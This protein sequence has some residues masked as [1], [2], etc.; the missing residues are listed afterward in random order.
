MNRTG[1]ASGRTSVRR[2]GSIAVALG[3][4]A[5]GTLMAA[6]PAQAA[7]L[8][9][10]GRWDFCIETT[11]D[12]PGGRM[13]VS[14]NGDVVQICD[15]DAD[16]KRAVGNVYRGSRAAGDA[17]K[18]YTFYDGGNNSG[19]ETRRAGMG[20]KFNLIENRVYTFQI[21]I[22]DDPGRDRFCSSYEE[23]N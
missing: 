12:N 22:D 3:L 19:C 14:M 11:D 6:G 5:A 18:V 7:D 8:C 23:Y 4:T 2:T 10:A 15:T 17:V 1:N 13:W 9:D 21:C 20:G 16:G